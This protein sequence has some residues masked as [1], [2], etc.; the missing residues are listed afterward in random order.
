MYKVKMICRIDRIDCGGFS[1][2]YPFIYKKG[3]CL[4]PLQ[5]AS[6]V[7]PAGFANKPR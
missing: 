3:V 2:S 4:D 1:R 5:V 6:R 7:N